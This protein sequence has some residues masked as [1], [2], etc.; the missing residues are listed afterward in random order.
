MARSKADRSH[1]KPTVERGPH[2][3]KPRCQGFRSD[4]KTQC[5]FPALEGYDVCS[6]K[7]SAGK[8]GAP[9]KHGGRSKFLPRDL[10]EKFL[11]IGLEECE[12]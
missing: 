1:F 11:E 2:K 4:G 7:H 8:G 9:L 12:M 3:G 6:Q 5:G 10:L